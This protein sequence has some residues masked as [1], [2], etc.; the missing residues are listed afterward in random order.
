MVN[1]FT[2]LLSNMDDKLGQL[3]SKS[4]SAGYSYEVLLGVS[5]HLAMADCIMYF[6]A[7]FV[8][9]M[10][11]SNLVDF[12]NSSAYNVLALWDVKLVA[13]LKWFSV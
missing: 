12:S 10:L 7:Q 5:I 13:T 1:I 6:K 4:T 3:R 9:C 8:A 11:T 2:I